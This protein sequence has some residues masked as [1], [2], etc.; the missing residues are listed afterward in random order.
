MGKAA[1]VAKVNDPIQIDQPAALADMS[2]DQLEAILKARKEAKAKLALEKKAEI[3][4]DLEM[5]L[6]KKWNGITFAE[7]G[8]EEKTARKVPDPVHYER[9]IDGKLHQYTYK[10]WGAA[11]ADTLKIFGKEIDGKLKLDPAYIVPALSAIPAKTNG[12]A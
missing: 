5:Y 3:L 1:T 7:L 4:A 9:T 11:A 6:R 2:D 12:A 10:G 8:L